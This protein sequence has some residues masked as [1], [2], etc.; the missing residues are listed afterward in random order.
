MT[1][2]QKYFFRCL[3]CNQRLKDVSDIISKCPKCSGPISAQM[4]MAQLKD[5]I[6]KE[7]FYKQK[8]NSMWSFF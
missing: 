4:N 5:V 3:K 6:S 8:I 2:K 7:N 1:E